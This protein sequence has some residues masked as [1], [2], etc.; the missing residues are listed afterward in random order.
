MAWNHMQTAIDHTYGPIDLTVGPGSMSRREALGAVQEILDRLAE[1]SP[2]MARVAAE[3]WRRGVPP[4]EVHAWCGDNTGWTISWR[5]YEYP[6]GGNPG[7]AAAALFD[8]SLL[9][10]SEEGD[11]FCVFVHRSPGIEAQVAKIPTLESL[12]EQ[13]AQWP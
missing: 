6:D 8:D 4:H 1:I 9:T 12:Q 10:D 2:K 11:G 3:T 7:R 13:S 5:I